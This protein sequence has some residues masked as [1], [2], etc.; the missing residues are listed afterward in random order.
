[1]TGENASQWPKKKIRTIKQQ[2]L[3]AVET[4]RDRQR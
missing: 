1:M 3:S 2:D 4:V